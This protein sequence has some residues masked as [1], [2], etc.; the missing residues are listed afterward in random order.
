MKKTDEENRGRLAIK[1]LYLLD[2]ETRIKPNL[3]GPQ[4]RLEYGKARLKRL[5]FPQ[6]NK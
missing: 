6:K 4:Q 1:D 2:P 3:T 5:S